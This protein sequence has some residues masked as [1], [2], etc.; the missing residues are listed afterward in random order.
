MT[1][2]HND[3]A[4]ENDGPSTNTKRKRG[5]S[6]DEDSLLMG[7]QKMQ[8][9]AHGNAS[10]NGVHEH[11]SIIPPAVTPPLPSQTPPPSSSTSAVDYPTNENAAK[12]PNVLAMTPFRKEAYNLIH[13]S[14]REL[15]KLMRTGRVQVCSGQMFLK[16]SIEHDWL[17]GKKKRNEKRI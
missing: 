2:K 6:E 16:D 8:K 11:S 1:R 17:G 7:Q 9:R 5:A 10:S 15:N 14:D 4:Q 3:C 13:I 12:Q